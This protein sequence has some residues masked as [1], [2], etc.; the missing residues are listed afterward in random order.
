MNTRCGV[1]QWLMIKEQGFGKFAKG[2][3][4]TTTGGKLNTRGLEIEW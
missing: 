3:E 4:K 2:S 1:K